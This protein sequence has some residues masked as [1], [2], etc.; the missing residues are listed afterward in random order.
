MS[1]ITPLQKQPP[2]VFHKKTALILTENTYR[3]TPALES[4]FNKVADLEV[5][6][7]METRLEHRFFSCEYSKIF[8]SI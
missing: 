4:L 2:E 5:Y 6:N 3:K 7:V 8:K 1:S